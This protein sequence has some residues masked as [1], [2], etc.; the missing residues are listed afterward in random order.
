MTTSTV[1]TGILGQNQRTAIVGAQSEGR[2]CG[3][4]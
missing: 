1:E 2:G 4:S 3:Q